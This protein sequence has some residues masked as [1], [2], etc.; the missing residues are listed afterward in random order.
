MPD[1]TTHP[2]RRDEPTAGLTARRIAIQ[3]IGFALGVA[4][5]VW[6]VRTAAR[7]G[8]WS[9]VRHAPPS[10]IAGLAACSLASLVINAG[11]FWTALRPV[12]RH[13][14]A[15]L[16]AL[17]GVTGLLNYAP[18]RLGLVARIAYHLRVDRMS[19]RLV[20]AWML[21]TA[22]IMMLALLTCGVAVA[23]VG[24]RW[25]LFAALVAAQLAVGQL[26]ARVA[27]PLPPIAA[28]AR[29]LDGLPAMFASPVSWW[30]TS[31]LRIAD[32]A[33]FT[34]RMA[35]AAEILGLSLGATDVILLALVAQLVSFSPL[36]RL[37]F[38]EA[39]VAFIAARLEG[40]AGSTSVDAIFAQLAL[41]ESAGEAAVLIPAGIVAMP[42]YWWSMRRG[43]LAGAESAA[44]K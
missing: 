16:T 7:G 32:I 41:V 26:L 14:I 37:G 33:A 8:D 10:F 9:R 34:G 12:W 23:V 11:M 13:S 20:A 15:R 1:H 30:G 5:I 17:N 43:R 2:P 4:L 29:R 24:P 19:A 42:W 39:A 31:A 27:L 40:G 35:F 44:T 25:P 3:L 22:G 38:R 21:F 28:I 6:C 18:V 36:G